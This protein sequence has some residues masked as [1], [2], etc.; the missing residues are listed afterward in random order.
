M[1]KIHR[2]LSITIVIALFWACNNKE[3]INQEG[4]LIKKTE[5]FNSIMISILGE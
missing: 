5:I 1:K 3:N 4:D 2:L